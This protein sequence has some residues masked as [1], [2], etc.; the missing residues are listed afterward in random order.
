MNITLEQPHHAAAVEALLDVAFGPDRHRKTTYRLREGVAALPELSYVALDEGED[1]REEVIGTI[2]YW[3]VLI[4]GATPSLML[5]PIAVAQHV[6]S[7][8][9]GSKLIGTTLDKARAL[10]HR[11]VIL[12]GDAPYYR[13]F[14]FTRGLTLGLFLPGPVDPDRFLGLEL[15]SGAL[16]SASGLVTRASGETAGTAPAARR[17][18]M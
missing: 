1:G 16:A 7:L 3:P 12:V 5:G 15:V 14:G 17:R 4:G 11:S 18:S 6:Q 13:R 10:G 9:L 8:G 2:R